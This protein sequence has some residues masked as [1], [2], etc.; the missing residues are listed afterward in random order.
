M[1]TVQVMFQEIFNGAVMLLLKVDVL[2]GGYLL[3]QLGVLETH[4]GSRSS[5]LQQQELAQLEHLAKVNKQQN[6]SIQYQHWV[7]KCDS[8]TL[9]VCTKT[10][11]GCRFDYYCYR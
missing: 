6:D 10:E 7:N 4:Y 2:N 3:R 1:V 8:V 11:I 5:C 9:L